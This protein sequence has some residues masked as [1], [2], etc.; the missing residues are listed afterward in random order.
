MLQDPELLLTDP[1]NKCKSKRSHQQNS[2]KNLDDVDIDEQVTED[3]ADFATHELSS[4][5]P[6]EQRLIASSDEDDDEPPEQFSLMD[7]KKQAL[8]EEEQKKQHI[9]R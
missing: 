9:A 1:H 4:T 5:M 2:K 8:I 3:M 7:A 6:A